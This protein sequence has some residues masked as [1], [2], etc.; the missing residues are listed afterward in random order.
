MLDHQEIQKKP[1]QPHH[2]PSLHDFQD[3]MRTQMPLNWIFYCA[4]WG[5]YFHMGGGGGGGGEV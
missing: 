5:K 1:F 3:E 4:F 2:Y